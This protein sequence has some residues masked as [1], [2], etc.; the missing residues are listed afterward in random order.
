MKQTF[1]QSG[2][3]ALGII[4]AF[5]VSGVV[6]N[7]APQANLGGFRESLPPE[8]LSFASSTD[9]FIVPNNESINPG[10]NVG[11][12]DATTTNML[13]RRIIATSTTEI[14]VTV[15]D[16]PCS[17]ANARWFLASTTAVNSQR[18]LEFTADSIPYWGSLRVCGVGGTTSV[19]F[20][21]ATY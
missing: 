15:N 18:A 10:N 16:E 14:L 20:L 9:V 7:V 13:F 12:L 11:W 19:S 17:V 8:I 5:V 3:I 6:S 21:K 1:I 4:I 2:I